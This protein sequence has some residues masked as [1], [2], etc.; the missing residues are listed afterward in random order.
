M[1]L[2]G[3]GDNAGLETA[4]QTQ[5]LG[6]SQFLGRWVL[7]DEHHLNCIPRNAQVDLLAARH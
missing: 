6:A 1:W 4:G 5:L 2:I 7:F 3:M